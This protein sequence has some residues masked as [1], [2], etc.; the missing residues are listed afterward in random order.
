MS[1]SSGMEVE[2]NWPAAGERA[3]EGED[4]PGDEE[5]RIID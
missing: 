2:I 1:G 3:G 5:G 4:C